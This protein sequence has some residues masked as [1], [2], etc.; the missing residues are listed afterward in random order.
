M[1]LERGESHGSG[2]KLGALWERVLGHVQLHFQ[3][4]SEGRGKR[5]VEKQWLDDV[6]F[7]ELVREKGEL[8]CRKIR[9]KLR[10]RAYWPK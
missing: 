1:G 7:K 10:G 4:L 9:H 5:D 2:G 3:W 6:D 8:Y